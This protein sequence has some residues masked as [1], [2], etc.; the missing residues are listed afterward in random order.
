MT[1]RDILPYIFIASFA[2]PAI[3]GLRR[4]PLSLPLKLLAIYSAVTLA[5]S[6]LMAYF[7][8]RDQRNI[9]MIHLFTPFEASMFLWMFSRWQVREVARLT[10]LI[11][12]P[13]FL[14]FWSFLTV[15]TE[16]LS[17][18]PVYGKSAEAIL[19]VAVAAW[20]LVTRSSRLLMPLTRYSWFWVCVG[21]L[22]YFPFLSA[23][24]PIS[25][26]LVT[27]NREL[28]ITMFQVNA[29]LGTAAN[30]LF[31]WGML[32]LQPHPSSGGSSSPQPSLAS[33]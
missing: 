8:S 6:C 7:S 11:A 5:E 2:V 18:F 32:C 21:T 9:W 1:S 17:E 23:L 27:E 14:V 30:L 13:M 26:L 24:N 12:I 16:S 28:V 15:T 3:A 19:L 22:V 31:A 4:R 10:V 20:T 29:V 33:S 25:R